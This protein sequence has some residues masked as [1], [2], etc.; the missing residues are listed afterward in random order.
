MYMKHLGS[1]GHAKHSILL[2]VILL[3]LSLL[4]YELLFAEITVLDPYLRLMV[5][6][7]NKWYKLIMVYVENFFLEK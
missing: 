3:F 6:I 1:V 2:S 5:N 4:C 7:I